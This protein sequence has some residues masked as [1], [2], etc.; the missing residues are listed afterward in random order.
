MLSKDFWICNNNENIYLGIPIKRKFLQ[1]SRL[2]GGFKLGFGKISRV[3][4][5]YWYTYK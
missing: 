5:E 4:W 1:I 3:K 2:E